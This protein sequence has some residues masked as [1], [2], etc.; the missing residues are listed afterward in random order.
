MGIAVTQKLSKINQSVVKTLRIVEILSDAKAP[1]RLTDLARE[2]GLT[3]STTLRMVNTLVACGYAWQEEGGTQGYAL[4]TRF[5]QV[6]QKIAANFSMM[7]LVHPRLLRLSRETGEAGTFARTMQGKVRYLD[8]VEGSNNNHIVIRQ[9]IGGSAY[10]HC[11]GSGKLFL[12]QYSPE[13]FERFLNEPL[14]ALTPHTITE[15]AVL[16]Q[17]LEVTRQR[18]YALDDEEYEIGMRCVAAPIQN[19]AG[20]TVGVISLSGPVSR[21]SMDRIERELLPA[22]RACAEQITCQMNGVSGISVN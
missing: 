17:E 13:E 20:R 14:P 21:M 12:C 8:V 4:T 3:P 5:A 16:E 7:D 19:A 9:Q 15:R 2:V 18:G 22:L 11:T 1:V 10:M 6:G